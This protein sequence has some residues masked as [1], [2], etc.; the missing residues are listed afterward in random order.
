[1]RYAIAILLAGCV[2]HDK[3]CNGVNS[4]DAEQRIQSAYGKAVVCI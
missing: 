1:M 3:G 4:E 2:T